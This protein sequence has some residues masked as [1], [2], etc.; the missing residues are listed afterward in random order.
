VLA[1]DE[2]DALEDQD[3]DGYS[4]T[5][6]TLA[7]RRHRR[8]RQQQVMIYYIFFMT[9]STNYFKVFEIF[10]GNISCVRLETSNDFHLFKKL[11]TVDICWTNGRHDFASHVGLRRRPSIRFFLPD[12]VAPTTENGVFSGPRIAA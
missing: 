4:N 5:K 1:E 2:L 6:E 8:Q 3:F 7:A 11:I 9:T 12:P 10:V